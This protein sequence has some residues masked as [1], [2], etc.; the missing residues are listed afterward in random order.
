MRKEFLIASIIFF[1]SI[2]Y[3]STA[4]AMNHEELLVGIKAIQ[5]QKT[6]ILSL[7]TQENP[8]KSIL[9]IN[10]LSKKNIELQKCLADKKTTQFIIETIDEEIQLKLPSS[11]KISEEEKLTTK[12]G[13]ALRLNGQGATDYFVEHF[14]S[15]PPENRSHYANVLYDLYHPSAFNKKISLSPFKLSCAEKLV[16]VLVDQDFDKIY[17]PSPFF[18]AAS[19]GQVQIV[20]LFIRYDQK[21]DQLYYDWLPFDGYGGLGEDVTALH[22]ACAN[23]HPDIVAILLAAG[24][25]VNKENRKGKT[26]L[27]YAKKGRQKF[28]TD[29]QRYDK[30]IQFLTAHGAIA[31]TKQN[32]FRGLA[33]AAKNGYVDTV[34]DLVTKNSNNP[35]FIEGCRYALKK[36][37]PKI[38]LGFKKD[39]PKLFTKYATIVLVLNEAIAETKRSKI[40]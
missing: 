36:V 4:Q 17:K 10:K 21:V 7:L 38:C 23:G 18:Q 6:T 39:H 25:S 15:I 13:I 26:P 32:Y 30:T 5:K 8:E 37:G 33:F 9:N 3:V 12:L 16:R 11:F 19:K 31:P 28:S 14:S 40:N 35:N 22:K 1:V 20:S 24:A 29:K 34:K 2:Y 27:Y